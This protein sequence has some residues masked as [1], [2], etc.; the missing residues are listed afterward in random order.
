M[1]LPA[2]STFAN[3]CPHHDLK[4][5]RASAAQAAAHVV[6]QAVPA[7][8]CAGQGGTGLV[9]DRRRHAGGLRVVL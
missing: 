1:A 2:D 4:V 6:R 7:R 9:R 8:E 3:V 5:R